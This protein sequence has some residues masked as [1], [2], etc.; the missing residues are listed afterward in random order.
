M[1]EAWGNIRYYQGSWPL[2]PT[3]EKLIS[4]CLIS[5]LGFLGYHLSSV[6]VEFMIHK[7]AGSGLGDRGEGMAVIGGLGLQTVLHHVREYACFHYL[8]IL[9]E[10][11]CMT[12]V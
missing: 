11:H 1:D 8:H 9:P 5:W 12:S 7:H 2:N 3:Q 10:V 4:S 6:D